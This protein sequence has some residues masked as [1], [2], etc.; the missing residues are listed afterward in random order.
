M[1]IVEHVAT[2]QPVNIFVGAL[3]EVSDG[4]D[5]QNISHQILTF[6]NINFPTNRNKNYIRKKVIFPTFYTYHL[7]RLKRNTAHVLKQ[8]KPDS[9][10]RAGR[11]RLLLYAEENTRS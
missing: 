4:R 9:P 3:D 7:A 5:D 2:M 10:R 11:Q 8:N 6:L 1:T